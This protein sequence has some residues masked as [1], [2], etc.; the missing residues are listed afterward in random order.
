MTERTSPNKFNICGLSTC[1]ILIIISILSFPA[2]AQSGGLKV[3]VDNERESGE[4]CVF[5][6]SKTLPCKYLNLGDSE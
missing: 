4:V 2:Y 3:I 1:V 5:S 6:E